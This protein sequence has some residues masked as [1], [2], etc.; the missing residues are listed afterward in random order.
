MEERECACH[1]QIEGTK[2]SKDTYKS[3]SE[4]GIFIRNMTYDWK[5]NLGEIL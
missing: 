2:Y 1:N 5:D 4:I 3:L